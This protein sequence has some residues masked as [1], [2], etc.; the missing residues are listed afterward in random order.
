[1]GKFENDQYLISRNEPSD[2]FLEARLTAGNRLQHEFNR[3][4][5]KEVVSSYDGFK[6]IKAELTSPSLDCLVFAY[7][8]AVFSVNLELINNPDTL[9]NR[10]MR[11]SWIEACE[12]NDLLPCL[13]RLMAQHNKL[14][15]AKND[16]SLFD[17]RNGAEIDPI[18]VA[19]DEPKEM[20]SWELHNFS[21]QVVKSEIEKLG[22]EVFTYCDI[23]EINPQIWFKDLNGN[24]NWVIARHITS[25]KDLNYREWVGLE[26]T[27]PQ[28]QPFDGFFA[29]VQLFSF[30]NNGPTNLN[31]G[32][33]VAVKY[34]G[35]ER[36]YA[37]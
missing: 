28:L 9:L 33:A 21:I 6:W 24:M 18:A 12:R 5:R 30:N 2:L 14:E 19:S 36:I 1:M 3:L 13:F 22:N 32:D 10:K 26:I 4:N 17:A 23:P 25:D 16:W 37:S 20:S 27:S 34:K 29:A 35:L 15:P 31:R 11:Q 8:N 7:K